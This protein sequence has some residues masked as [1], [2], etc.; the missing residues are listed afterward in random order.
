MVSRK[1]A[2][3]TEASANRYES[4]IN[5][6]IAV[7]GTGC[8][9]PGGSSSPSKLWDM[10]I[11]RRDA[12]RNID[13]WSAEGFHHSNGERSGA[14]NVKNAYLL[15]E[16]VKAWDASFFGINPREA[17]AV[18]PQHRI[19]L[20]TVYEA[21][22]AGGFSMENMQGSDTAVYVGTMTADYSEMLLRGPEN[23][24]TYFATGTN[25]SI[26]SNRVSYFFDL[27]GPSE[28]INTACSSSLVAVHHCV[29]SLRNGESRMAIAGGANLILNPEFMASESN[30]HMLSAEGRSRMWD[31]GANGYARGEGFAAVILK[32]LSDA[33]VDGDDI[34]CIIRETG[35]N[36]DGRT[37]GITLPS[38]EAQTSLIKQVYAKA[39]LNSF[40]AI[41]RPQYFEAHG[42]GTPAGDPIEANGIRDAFFFE[43]VQRE[44]EKLIVGS[45]KT[46]VG[47]TEGTA[48]L[49]GLIKVAQA[50]KRATIPGNLLFKSY[51]PKILPLLEHLEL[52][53]Q[54]LPWPAPLP[55]APRRASVNCFGF[56]GTNSHA[57]VESYEPSPYTISRKM[58]LPAQALIAIPLVLSANNESSLAKMVQNYYDL[59]EA[60]ESINLN[61]LAWTLA[62]RRSELALKVT[63]AGATREALLEN[64]SKVLQKTKNSP[65]SN[66]GTRRDAR[67]KAPRILGVF[68]GQGAQWPNMGRDILLN[69]TMA[70]ESI[71][72][73][74]AALQELPET[75]RPKWTLE[76]IIC[77]KVQG[78]RIDEAEFSQPVC[79]AVQVMLVD[80]LRSVGH[81]FSAVVGHSSGEIGAAYAA[82]V[83]TASEAIKIAYYRGFHTKLA[84]GPT[85]KQGTMLAAGLSHEDA[86]EF[87]SQPQL[88]GRISVAASNA[89]ESVTLSG[90]VDA[91]K[92]A[93]QMLDDRGIFARALKVNKAYHSQHMNPVSPPYTESLRAQR[94]QPKLPYEGC[95]WISSV[96]GDPIEDEMDLRALTSVYWKDNMLKPVLFSTAVEQAVF[97][98]EPFDYAM[99]VGPHTALKGPFLQTFKAAMGGT[100]PYGGTLTRHAEDIGSMATSLGGLMNYTA[101]CDFRTEEY[102]RSFQA[103][104]SPAL[105]SGLPCYPWD[106]SQQYWGESRYSKKYRTRSKARHDL[107]GAQLPDDLEHDLRYRNTV[108]V[109]ETPWLAGHKV[110]GQI[111]YPG[112]AYIAMAL[113]A[114][115]D[116][117]GD[118]P[119]KMVELLDI[120]LN[121]AI[122]LEEG[123]N[124]ADT[125][126]TLKKT[127]EGPLNGENFI[128]AEFSIFSAVGV[129]AE[130]WDINMKG[131]MRIILAD[132][133]TPDIILPERDNNP[134]LL[135]KLHVE[136]FY[137]TLENIG[138]NY[139]GLFRRLETI[140]RRM[141]RATATAIEYPEDPEMPVMM[142]PALMDA[143][144]QT[145]FAALHFPGDGGMSCPYLPTGIKCLRISTDRD[146]FGPEAEVTIDTFVTSN[147]N[148][149]ICADIE[150]FS[151]ATGAPRM[152]IEGLSCTALDRAT[153]DNDIEL[154]AQTVYRPE[155]SKSATE[156]EEIDESYS[157][158]SLVNL[159]ERLAYMYLRKLNNSVSRR[160]VEE[161]SWNHQRIFQFIDHLFPVVENGQHDS[162]KA[163]WADDDE[164]WLE[165]QAAKHMD[166]VDVQLITTVGQN[167]LSVVRGQTNLLECMM[168]DDM[169]N[170]YYALGQQ[171]KESNSSLSRTVGQIVHRYAGM[172]ILEVGA[173][174]GAVTKGVIGEIGHLFKSY[175]FT[176]ATDKSFDKAKENLFQWTG[177]MKFQALEIE[178]DV[179]DQGFEEGSYDLIIASNVVQTSQNLQKTMENIR[180]LLKPGGYVVLQEISV[181][182]VLRV[183][184]MTLGLPAWWMGDDDSRRFGPAAS[185]SQWTSLL[186][187]TGFSGVDQ[188]TNDLADRPMYMTSVVLSQA[189]TDEVNFLRE[190]LCPPE[191]RVTIRDICII[192]NNSA[193][194]AEITAYIEE[195]CKQLGSDLPKIS[196]V[197]RVEKLAEFKSDFSAVIFLQDLDEPIWKNL[198]QDT[199]TGL[200]NIVDRS[201]Q[202]LWVTSGCRLENA[203][204][205]MSLGVGRGLQ[206][207]YAHVQ[208][209]LLDVEPSEVET[210]NDL[211]AAAAIR[212]FAD[213]DIRA[214]SPNILWTAEEEM[215]IKGGKFL[216]PRITADQV[217]NDRLNARR[218]AIEKQVNPSES[219]VLISQSEGNYVVAEPHLTML[220]T[221]SKTDI[222]I[223]VTHSLLAAIKVG[224][225]QNM[226][227]TIGKVIEGGDLTAGK[228]V[229]AFSHVNASIISVPASQVV[230]IYVKVDS[231]PKFIESV[232]T[233][234]VSSALFSQLRHGSTVL[235][236]GPNKS[237]AASFKNTAG[238]LGLKVFH[239]STTPTTDPEVVYINPHTSE[240]ALRNILPKKIDMVLDFSTV[241]QPSKILSLQN[242]DECINTK[243][244]DLFGKNATSNKI[245]DRVK[246][247]LLK[248][249]FV[250]ANFV[251][252]TEAPEVVT[253]KELTSSSQARAY[254]AVLD[255]TQDTEVSVHVAP[256]RTEN[257]FR[258]D[259]TY[260]LVGC[261]GGLGQALCRWM[262]QNGAKHLALTT[263]NPKSVNK[264]WYNEM[265]RAGANVQVFACDVTDGTSL[266]KTHDEITKIMPKVAGV[267]N[268]AMVLADRLFNDI[269]FED[270]QK[271]LKPKVDG[272]DQ[273]DELFGEGS[274]L[275]FFILFSSL[276]NTVGNRGQSN[277][278]AAN[279]YMQTIA[280]QRRNRGLTASVMHIGMVIGIGVVSQDAALETSL[281]RQKWMAISEPAF[282]DMFAECILVGRPN[283]GHSNDIIT[284][285]PRNSTLNADDNPWY[286]ANHRF[287]HYVLKKEEGE[288]SSAGGAS[289]PIKQRLMAATSVEQ[290][291]EIIRGDFLL[292]MSRILQAAVE[293]IDISQPL[294]ALGVD[295][296]MAMEIRSWFLGQI[297]VDMP[298]LKVLGGGSV[299]TLCSDA[300]ALVKISAE[301]EKVEQE[302]IPSE[303][304]MS[305]A[306]SR[307]MTPDLLATPP[308]TPGMLSEEFQ[309]VSREGSDSGEYDG[310]ELIPGMERV[311][312]MSF[313][314]ERLWFL[315][316]FLT[317]PATYNITLAYRI[318]GP[319]R[320]ADFDQAFYELIDRHETLRT[321]FFTDKTNYLGYLGAVE[322]T[323][324]V[325]EQKAY[326]GEDQIKEE[327]KRTNEHHYD[328]E[329]AESMKAT[330]LIE[331]AESYVLIMGFHH[332]A[333]DATSSSILVR[334][335]AAIYSG[336][337][338]A[339]L[340][341]QYID[342]ANKQRM[343]VEQ[344]L[345]TDVDYWKAE[346][347]DIPET[348]PLFDFGT[349]KSRKPLTEYNLRIQETRLDT[350][351]SSNL[352]AAAQKLQVTPFHV[353]LATLQVMLH[354]LLNIDDICIG[355][356]DANKNDPDH[357]DTLGFFVNLLPLR[358]KV[359]G[360][361]SF[362]KLAKQAKD[363]TLSAL[364]H[365]QTPYNVLLD[366]LEVPRSTTSNPLFQVLMNY[367]MG[368]LRDVPIG[369]C[370]GEVIDFADA[371]NPYD[372]QF[373][374]E[375][376]VDGTTLVTVSTQSYLYSEED[377]S[378]VLNTYTHL[379]KTLSSKPS[380]P[381][382]DQNLFTTKASHTAL[383]IGTG[384]RI[385]IDQNITINKMFDWAVKARGDTVA[386][387]DNYG[388]SL[389]WNDMA[390]WVSTI[391][392]H[393]LTLD[394]K[395]QSFIGVNCEP[396]VMSVCYWLAI[397]RIG[398][399]YVPLDVSN[400]MGRLELIVEDCSPAAIICDE[401][402][403]GAAQK[404][405]GVAD[406]HIFKLSDIAHIRTHFAED[407][408]KP[409][410]TACV[411]YTSGTTG[412]P[413]GTM[414]TNS[415]FVNHIYGVNKAW[416]IG[417]GKEVILQ[418]TNLGF[419]LSLAQMMQFIASQGKMVVASVQTRTD[420]AEL[421]K[422]MVEY[423]VTYTI[424]TPSV[425]SLIL[426][427]SPALISQ[428]TEWRSAFSCGEPLTS[429]IVKE[430]QKA[431]L[432]KLRLINSCG[433]TEITI[434]NSA[435]EIPLSDPTASEQNMIVGRS[436][437]NYS[438]YILD[439]NLNPVP[440]GFPGEMVCGGASISQ[441]Y[442][443]QKEL[444][445]AKWVAD[446]FASN[447]DL[448]KGWNRMYRTGDRA[449]MLPDGRFVFLGRI[450]GD[451]QVKLRGVRIELDEVKNT[452]VRE[453]KGAITEAAVCLRGEGEQAFMVAFAVFTKEIADHRKFLTGLPMP[454]AY[455]PSMLVAVPALPR[456]P[457]GK[458]DNR[459]LATLELPAFQ[460]EQDDSPIELN[461]VEAELKNIWS[462]CLPPGSN[463]KGIRKTSDFFVLG[464]NS[465]LLVNVQAMIRENLKANIALYTLF[466]S[467]SLEAM[468]SQVEALTTVDAP[469]TAI[470]WNAETALDQSLFEP[471]E[472]SLGLRPVSRSYVEVVLS[473]AT[474]FLGTQIL[475][476]LVAD[477]RVG[478]IHCVAIRL[479]DGKASRQ[480]PV[481][482]SKIVK[483]Y[484]DLTS[485]RLGLTE[486]QFNELSKKADRIIHNGC[487]VSFLKSYKSL[488]ASNVGSTKELVRMA[489]VRKTPFHFVSTAGVAS[490]VPE[491]DLGERFIPEFSPP[492]DGSMG[493]AASKWAGEKY[494]EACSEQL[495]LPVFVHRPSNILGEGAGT[496]NMTANIMEYSMR[497]GAVP[498]TPGIDGYIQFVEVEE[499]GYMICNS[500]FARSQGAVVKNHCGDDN[501][502]LRDLGI[503]LE[504][505]YGNKLAMIELDQWI[506][507]VSKAGLNAGLA[508]LI[509]EVLRNEGGTAS[510]KTLSRKRF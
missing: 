397:L 66:I 313:S 168:K 483:Y 73:M 181:P 88:V 377:L 404:A 101:P 35:V 137:N 254:P 288:D 136:T 125:L 79:T 429:S 305:S 274:D 412:K 64:M 317:N 307:S 270:F 225:N 109:S 499:V 435:W 121:R 3:A 491:T 235:F 217:L 224:E 211:L 506:E 51:N 111:V 241:D 72:N 229:L 188:V 464:G 54:T 439:D 325:M 219:Q 2:A 446:P 348:L 18:D 498:H 510:L 488:Q 490:F 468:A 105:V 178:G 82:G 242:S 212:L 57:I 454:S 413:K 258:D 67:T 232:A 61:D 440:V 457:N 96:T 314:Q 249:H 312:R 26:L 13:R 461:H 141:N 381:I 100:L 470:D 85:G 266:R 118:L 357:V 62:N 433:P 4:Y 415:N 278:L 265:V 230:P 11:E 354:R 479:P 501:V 352:K 319:F 200:Q 205:N 341:H 324:F 175:T 451:N 421:V 1:T 423:Q 244:H 402:T 253:L 400:P 267:A 340:K 186:K 193:R 116:L 383:Q 273:L 144:F 6:P 84:Q 256:I 455:I 445:A 276:A 478:K 339:P 32:K 191:L 59:I 221:E 416:D 408:S 497:I 365:S 98:Q 210:S 182:D 323:P 406:R 180:S 401:I 360:A 298:V 95:K 287:S 456:T 192:G 164:A 154:Y 422:L 350:G 262:V 201:K 124:G 177:K 338:L 507:E 447:D 129:D 81:K 283:S 260:L 9:F 304:S 196:F 8:R 89:P 243:I 147:E 329:N 108:R 169:L 437:P 247:E 166:Q 425:Y 203:Y 469:T 261:T 252:H 337:Q 216:I 227:L 414:L 484:G 19:L 7:V 92:E 405:F 481:E 31:A 431:A 459:A 190:P 213:E 195:S 161:F 167:L 418:P 347:P 198:T 291:S 465:M 331:N 76:D 444:S 50:I 179:V 112:A 236:L 189:V 48:G 494:L 183:K 284:G 371:S 63:F 156:I 306:P 434:I 293:N 467:S 233:T 37:K 321:A 194:N 428:L 165:E 172:K 23:L 335:I 378:T 245:A 65:P 163:E 202:V 155:I 206:S 33:I 47:H 27:K 146:E 52:A 234:F 398:A 332:I 322:H 316:S 386:V 299:S 148:M 80:I 14:L 504:N 436:L 44:G 28:T 390:G 372:L 97:G 342:Y 453:S 346:F 411:I 328:L 303:A 43:D 297:D 184:F 131:R 475:R 68:T 286:A 145:C 246:D 117:A 382:K 87:C 387:V 220:A 487:D 102:V 176:D 215:I 442:L 349:V 419:D 170:R 16:D 403:I 355:I 310:I 363:K 351:F 272:T 250:A 171:I 226:Y 138:F 143:S 127:H 114:S 5:E 275:D 448:A 228:D 77:D 69:S 364:E 53:K 162:I 46:S 149:K 135:S 152:Q 103:G 344:A 290:K 399:I 292:K 271:C 326:T 158:L 240:R 473:G 24:P 41:D 318:K 486:Q 289:L 36:S 204:A 151:S 509:R 391:A 207:E 21:M 334:D 345:N 472:L 45:V 496:V 71:K 239:A 113:E 214:S 91:V 308:S 441:C 251:D 330:L 142:H 460:E 160:E 140:D 384:P 367:K 389:S 56:G 237:L 394:V 157:E 222:K 315:Q 263:R 493:Y 361:R 430:F 74:D 410:D 375:Q 450:N 133:N 115:K 500:L 29:Q 42:T 268:A 333:V 281:K 15:Q 277:Y 238:S 280:A 17:E 123:S 10:L 60:D 39:G 379:L 505:K 55:G 86:D 407:M 368:S 25:S 257:L 30:L 132:S 374:V 255:F 119:T 353:H 22:E 432:P 126:L 476:E 197:P 373:D 392:T 75:D 396:S 104:V 376:S 359:E 327:F 424:V 452:I 300:A 208:I 477:E 40:S 49:A 463:V 438:T 485:E 409:L 285:L 362:A 320:V 134:L 94:I 294:L 482:S 122:G 301:P 209:Q 426:R 218:R 358:F 34:T 83:V 393:L 248:A 174:S 427:Q 106:H 279:G 130:S 489:M 380:L 185:I 356:T 417:L 90:D 259:K 466:Q 153:E 150:M 366:K 420:P 78:K 159:C 503:F 302:S 458:I 269:T 449:K 388:G 495:G 38:G 264:I 70:K 508:S 471:S 369:E 187:D 58:L 385:D 110:Q 295:S 128:E 282:L 173:G 99:E 443:H 492:T 231:P 370:T 480:L 343:L 462:K 139:Q 296:L 223:K 309:W 120:E 311:G 336:Q 199:I 20:E 502:R 395:P 474:G 107:L 12:L 93:K